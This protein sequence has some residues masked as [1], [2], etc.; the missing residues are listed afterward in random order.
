MTEPSQRLLWVHFPINWLRHSL[1]ICSLTSL[2]V[3]D[4][5]SWPH[6]SSTL[7]ILEL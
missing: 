6:L 3:Y 2:Q 4:R 5:V 7:L 1:V